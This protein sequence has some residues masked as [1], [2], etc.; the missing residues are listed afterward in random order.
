MRKCKNKIPILNKI[1]KK[2]CNCYLN[3]IKTT[4]YK[5]MKLTA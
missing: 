2:N 1:P 3:Y 5:G 4:I